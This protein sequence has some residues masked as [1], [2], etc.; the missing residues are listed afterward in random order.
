[1]YRGRIVGI[2]PGDTPRDVLGL[3]MAGEAR[4][5][6]RGCRVS[7]TDRTRSEAA[8]PPSKWHATFL[9][10][11]QGNAIIS[12]L[13]VVLAL[14]VGGILIAV[15]DEDV[16]AAA[17]YFF[18]RPGDTLVAIWDAVSG[19]YIA[20]FQG[21]V[22]NFGAPTFARAIRPL[23][24]TLTFATPLIA[25]GL[26]VALAFRIGMF[27]IGG[28]GQMLMA[29]AAA[30]LGGV[31]VRPAVG[32]AHDR[33]AR[34]GRRRGRAVG[35]HRGLP[36]GAHRRARGD[37]DDH[38]QL[39]RRSTSCCGCCAPPACSR[40]RA[41]T[42]RHLAGVQG[43]ARSSPSCSDRSSTCTSDSS[44][45]IAATVLVW[46]ILEPLQPRLPVPCRRRE[47]ERR[48]RRG[49]QRQEHVPLR[50]ADLRR[51]RRASPA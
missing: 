11:T 29:A 24:E 34:R 26:G 25:A 31:L 27:N 36:E 8:P 46:W 38:A 9:K 44:W 15:T 33:R 6:R 48:A 51:P 10:I 16:Q 19:A 35:R 20:F 5:R 30:E 28:R 40:R 1:M 37:R 22:Y 50:D 42:T 41:R 17:G 14:L 23:T 47:P 21:A 12:V 43:H 4:R 13:A 45:S 39:R 2:V 18:A 49:H 3:M 7:T 32:P